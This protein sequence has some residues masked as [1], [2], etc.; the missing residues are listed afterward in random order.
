MH[1]APDL[2]KQSERR[3]GLYKSKMR[4]RLQPSTERF[5]RYKISFFLHIVYFEQKIG[6]IQKCRDLGG[7]ERSQNM[8]ILSSKYAGIWV[9]VNE[10][11]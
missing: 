8:A 1:T 6:E 11:Q 5:F 10:Y 4:I 7:T 3:E 9:I 2:V